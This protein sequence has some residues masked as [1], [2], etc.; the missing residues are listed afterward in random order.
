MPTPITTHFTPALTN[1]SHHTHQKIN[2]QFT[3]SRLSYTHPHPSSVSST[4]GWGHT[5]QR[6]ANNQQPTLNST[7]PSPTYANTTQKAIS[8]NAYMPCLAM[9]WSFIASVPAIHPLM[10]S[11]HPSFRQSQKPITC[12]HR[13]HCIPS[14]Q[15]Q[16]TRPAS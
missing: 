8:P 6:T 2:F 7:Q 13:I 14:H 15:H 3:S 16:S 4:D 11:T 1:F 5:G 9:P 10:P 12:V